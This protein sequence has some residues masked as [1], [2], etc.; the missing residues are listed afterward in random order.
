ME[1]NREIIRTSV[2][3]I[4]ANL[5]LA[6]F[7]AVVGAVAGSIAII[8]DAV[9][10]L[11]DALSSGITILGTKLSE[12]PADRMHPFGHGR[13]EYFSAIVISVIVLAAGISSL[14]ESL[15]KVLH[16]VHPDYTTLTLVVVSVAIVVKLVLGRYVKMQG[17][18]LKSD[19]LKA[20]G[21]D[22]LF[23]ALITLAT[24]VSAIIMLVWDVSIDGILGTAISLVIIKS[25]V[26][27]LK[28]PVNELLGCRISGEL[29]RRIKEEVMAFEGVNGVFDIIL[30]TYG[31]DTMIG[32]LHV[33]VLD[34]TSASAIHLLGRR[35]SECLYSRFGIIATVGFY[36]INTSDTTIARIQHDVMKRV[37]GYPGIR[38]AHGFFVDRPG[39]AIIFDIM[40]DYE[41][42]DDAALCA[43]LVASLKADYPDYSFDI[44]I[45]HN[46]SEE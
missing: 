5:L 13:V 7:K 3:G 14:V 32:S 27:M 18:K 16:P 31:P 24:L 1:R 30:H 11:S 45:D 2:V 28:S 34:T 25:G 35:I 22:A 44:A 12:R 37:F 39:K 8:M 6:A 23:D 43:S 10:N 46:Y 38:S 17:Q 15:Q 4:A 33:S 42:K 20:S 26:D 21:A 41:V 40:P 9:N 29:V 19:A 36:A